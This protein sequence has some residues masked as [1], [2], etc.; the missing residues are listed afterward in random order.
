MRN[1]TRRPAHL[2]Q[3]PR[4]IA[5][6]MFDGGHGEREAE[7]A[8]KMATIYHKGQE[9]AWDGQA[10]LAACAEANGGV[11]LEPEKRA[12]LVRIVNT[13]FWGELIAWKV[14]AALSVDIEPMEA[15]M[16]AT[17]QTHDEARHFYVLRDWMALAGQR[18]APMGPACAR[19]FG[20][21]SAASDLA[22]KLIG[23][24]LMVEPMALTMFH[25]LRARRVEPVLADLLGYFEKDEARHVALGVGWLPTL[26]A[27]MTPRERAGLALWQV[28]TVFLQLDALA[29]LAPDLGALG[30]AARDVFRLGQRRQLE[31][32]ASLRAE[33]RRGAAIARA[34]QGLVEMR[35]D[36]QFPASD[37]PRGLR[38]RLAAAAAAARAG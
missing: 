19:F 11:R 38:A 9:L 16:A 3:D 36:W 25:M 27:G 28:R 23:M 26:V 35:V 32:S 4:R 37:G 13:V 22:R 12:A 8:R 17:A 2:G 7:I 31:A 29:E 34:V 5:Y 10:V 15:K 20:E 33:M 1:P 14:S 30:I 18:P 6:D 24:Q 21:V